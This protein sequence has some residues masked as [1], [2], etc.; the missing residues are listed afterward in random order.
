VTNA[1]AVITFDEWINV[2][3]RYAVALFDR[4]GKTVAQHSTDEIQATLGLPMSEVT[5]RAKNGWWMSAAPTLNAAGD[6]ARVATA[7]KTLSVQLLDG[8][9]TAR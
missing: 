3:T 2:S 8:H 1:G 9:L 4:A 6:E 5:R 7:G